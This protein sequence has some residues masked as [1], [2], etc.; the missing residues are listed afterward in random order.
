MFD[1]I[2]HAPGNVLDRIYAR[3]GIKYLH[4]VHLRDTGTFCITGFGQLAKRLLTL[5]TT[6]PN[7]PLNRRRVASCSHFLIFPSSHW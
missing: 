4:A 5:L 7:L 6:S 1:V 2:H 3:Q